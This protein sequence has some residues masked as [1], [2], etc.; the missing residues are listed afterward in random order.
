MLNKSK[1]NKIKIRSTKKKYKQRTRKNYKYGGQGKKLEGKNWIK[2][3]YPTVD[4]RE[5][6][7][8]GFDIPN[9]K[10]DKNFNASMDNY[11]F[12]EMADRDMFADM[13]NKLS[14]YE[15]GG[16]TNQYCKYMYLIRATHPTS[17]NTVLHYIC[18]HKSVEMFQLVWPYYLIL[19]NKDFP[20]LLAHY[21]NKTNS[22]L[23]TPLQL[24]NQSISTDNLDF[25]TDL[26]RANI[27]RAITGIAGVGKNLAK[28][29]V[30]LP[31]FAK[32][33]YRTIG[34]N[35]ESR[36]GFIRKVLEQFSNISPSN[37]NN[38]SERQQSNRMNVLLRE[39]QPSDE[40][41]NLSSNVQQANERGE[42]VKGLAES[43][44]ADRRLES[45]QKRNNGRA[46]S[47]DLRKKKNSSREY[48]E[49][50]DE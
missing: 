12:L 32:S 50:N 44:E 5:I 11:K 41:L 40:L 18:N 3:D 36:S 49:S 39:G 1:R 29:L 47:P 7:K 46:P 22:D 27:S 31:K 26:S 2:A 48:L 4:Y 42:S 35:T 37:G 16:V 10:I 28:N 24:L 17:G 23:K 30:N 43:R 21:I 15:L 13:Q 33:V 19:Y 45:A 8:I 25:R 38:S 20:E 6:V 34:N 9:E 14:K